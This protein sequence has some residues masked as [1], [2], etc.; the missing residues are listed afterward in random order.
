MNRKAHLAIVLSMGIASGLLV[1]AAS[2]AQMTEGDEAQK[3]LLDGEAL[4]HQ[5]QVSAARLKFVD[6]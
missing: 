2:Q 3:R 5:K 1:A 4:L 6:A